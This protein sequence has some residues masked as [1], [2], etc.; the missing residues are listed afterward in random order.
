[1]IFGARLL[2]IRKNSSV[3][4]KCSISI[5]QIFYDHA[6]NI[7]CMSIKDKKYNEYSYY[8]KNCVSIFHANSYSQLKIPKKKFSRIRLMADQLLSMIGIGNYCHF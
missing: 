2:T 8:N 1:M 6:M 5:G 4:V 3:G 7:L